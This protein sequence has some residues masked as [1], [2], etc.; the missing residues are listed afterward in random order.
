MASPSLSTATLSLRVA[1]KDSESFP[2]S[3]LWADGP[4]LV[5]VLRRPGCREF[6][7]TSAAPAAFH[8]VTCL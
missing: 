4:V 5:V 6:A 8:D 7:A 2:A 3:K 1:G